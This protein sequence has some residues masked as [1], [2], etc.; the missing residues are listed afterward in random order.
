LLKMVRLMQ[1]CQTALIGVQWVL[2]GVAPSGVVTF[3]RSI[4]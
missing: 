4:E 1:Q 3:E 2:K